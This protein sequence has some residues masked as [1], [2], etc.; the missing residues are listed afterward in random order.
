MRPGGAYEDSST[1]RS[2]RAAAIITGLWAR[3]QLE[4]QLK[5]APAVADGS[6]PA[7]RANGNGAS[8]DLFFPLERREEKREKDPRSCQLVSVRGRRRHFCSGVVCPFPSLAHV[9]LRGAAMVTCCLLQT[10]SSGASD[11]ADAPRRV[12]VPCEPAIWS[13]HNGTILIKWLVF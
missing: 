6:S 11:P 8:S 5:R 2:H 9:R 13:S 12:F 10:R 7:S 3:C 4:R 1:W